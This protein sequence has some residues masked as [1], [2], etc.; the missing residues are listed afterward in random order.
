MCVKS[1]VELNTHDDD[2]SP[3]VAAEP[4]P[5]PSPAPAPAPSPA[6]LSASTAQDMVATR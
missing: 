6:W 3:P 4:A 5:A 1:A 2:L